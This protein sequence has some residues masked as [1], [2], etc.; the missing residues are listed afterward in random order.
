MTDREKD[1]LR[2]LDLLRIQKQQV[3]TEFDKLVDELV[4]IRKKRK[5]LTYICSDGAVVEVSN[6]NDTSKS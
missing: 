6:G 3:N 5:D 1:I 4:E 2:R